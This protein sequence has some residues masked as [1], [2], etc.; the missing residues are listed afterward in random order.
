MLYRPLVGPLFNQG[1]TSAKKGSVG[2]F[3]VPSGKWVMQGSVRKPVF[4]LAAPPHEQTP[5]FFSGTT[6]LCSSWSGVPKRA[7]GNGRQWPF[8]HLGRRL[9][10][11][12]GLRSLRAKGLLDQGCVVAQLW[13]CLQY[14]AWLSPCNQHVVHNASSH[15]ELPLGKP[16]STVCMCVRSHPHLLL[17]SPVVLLPSPVVLRGLLWSVSPG[18]PGMGL[19]LR[20]QGVGSLH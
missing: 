8:W 5:N 12:E 19:L 15:L 20:V 16:F 6:L 7:L 3:G 13:Q 2:I 14:G 11:V 10:C 1:I 18:G 17:P 9:G 4:C